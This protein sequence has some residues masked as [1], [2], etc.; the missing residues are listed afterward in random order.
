MFRFGKSSQG[1]L[2]TVDLRLQEVC[3][4]ALSISH[5]D[6]GITE[7]LRS[8]ERAELLKAEGKSKLGKLS[9]HCKGLAVDIVC[10]NAGKI[11]WEV[12]FYQE[13]AKYFDKARQVKGVDMRWGGIWKV[14]E[15]ELD[16]NNTFV[17]AVHFELV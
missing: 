16:P 7:G 3:H 12:E 2:E 13:V 1:K 14:N 6:F 5:I 15:F 9:K 10:Y 11:T 4:Y 17:D 8:E